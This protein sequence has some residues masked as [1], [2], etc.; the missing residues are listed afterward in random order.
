MS[1]SVT[2]I[3][4]SYSINPVTYSGLTKNM[5]KRRNKKIK[6][7]ATYGGAGGVA[8]LLVSRAYTDFID[9]KRVGR[10]APTVI[11]Q[12]SNVDAPIAGVESSGKGGWGKPPNV[13]QFEYDDDDT[14][15][16]TYVGRHK[17]NRGCKIMNDSEDV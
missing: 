10:T 9:P 4:R 11:T 8:A 15:G 2:D 12:R 1:T 13:A 17:R 6:H 7:A 16:W 14:R 5:R 3:L